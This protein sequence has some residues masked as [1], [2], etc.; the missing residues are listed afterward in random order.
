MFLLEMDVQPSAPI[1]HRIEQV[2]THLLLKLAEANA[3]RMSM[4]LHQPGDFAP[5]T[6]PIEP[7]PHGEVQSTAIHIE[8][9]HHLQEV[10]KS[11]FEFPVQ[12]PPRENGL[13]SV[14]EGQDPPSPAPS[15]EEARIPQRIRKPKPEAP[16]SQ[17]MQH[18]EPK[19]AKLHP[20]KQFGDFQ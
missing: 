7:R 17:A 9:P 15:P 18:Q 3:A 13:A 12:L 8:I 20:Y 1:Y 2:R 16:A 10:A 19:P 6:T 14:F 11:D 5:P 4:P